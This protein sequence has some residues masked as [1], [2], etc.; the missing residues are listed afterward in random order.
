MTPAPSIWFHA[1]SV[2]EVLS[3]AELIRRVR[4]EYAAAPVYLSVTTVAGRELAEQK[5]AADVD[6][7][8]YAPIDYPRAVRRV[9]R[10]LRPALL[11]VLETEIWPSLY[12]EAKRSGAAVAIVNARISDRAFPRYRRIR[13]LVKAVLSWPDR[14]LVQSER[15]RDRYLE[16]GAPAERVVIGGNLKYD[17]APPADIAPAIA[18]FLERTAP[19][20]T[21]IA[22]STMPPADGGDV[23]ED[24]AVLAAFEHLRAAYPDLLLILVPRKPER[25][26]VVAAKLEAARIPYVRR[27]SLTADTRVAL[28]GVFLLDS[29]GELS[30]LFRA[31]TVVFMG[32]TLARRGGHN[33]LEPAFFGTPVIIGPHM[34]NFAA[35]ADEFR[36]GGAV[37]EIAG[38]EDLAPAVARLLDDQAARERMG[39]ASRQLAESKR[40]VTGVAVSEILRLYFCSVPHG[41]GS[42]FLAPFSALWRAETRRRRT[43]A[44]GSQRRLEARVVSIGNLSAGGAGKTPLVA[45]L[46]RHAR[47]QGREPCILTRGY[48]RRS[49]SR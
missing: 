41:S 26:D 24:D 21:W 32:G 5:L 25:F 48:G 16:L 7:I 22:A 43:N 15:D 31:A 17:F 35:I 36:A 6:A 20:R 28:P 1:V 30:A 29:I 44:L 37:I 8:F 23:D 45:W 2:G 9:L 14:I 10:K 11:V 49:P 42:P 34:E 33:I 18:G 19:G 4:R 39:A 3:A 47:M 27:S 12:R 13:R 38:P 46:A 40:G